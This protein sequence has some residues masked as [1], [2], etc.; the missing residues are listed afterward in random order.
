[1]VQEKR[2]WNK[3]AWVQI[4]NRFLFNRFLNLSQQKLKG[5]GEAKYLVGLTR[6]N[7]LPFASVSVWVRFIYNC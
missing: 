2:F 5:L 6:V 7:C 3:G 1:M 4:I